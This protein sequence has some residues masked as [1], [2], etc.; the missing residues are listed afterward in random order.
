[1]LAKFIK[2]HLPGFMRWKR[3]GYYKSFSVLQAKVKGDQF[4][5][6]WAREDSLRGQYI[7]RSTQVRLSFVLARLWKRYKFMKGCAL[8]QIAPKIPAREDAKGWARLINAAR[9]IVRT[10]GV[11]EEYRYPD[12]PFK[13]YFY[14]HKVS[15][16]CTFE[17]PKAMRFIDDRQFRERDE[18]LIHGCTLEQKRLL[19]RVQ[20]LYRGYKIRSYYLYVEK[21]ME[22]SEAAER[23]YMT[24]PEK[25]SSLYNYALH[26]HIILHDYD[27]A[28]QL[29]AEA[30]RRME[31]RGPDVG[32]VLYSYA[33]F[34]YFTHDLDY[35]DV[36]VML[37]RARKAE[38]V[39]EQ[40]ARQARGEE[41]SQA[42]DNGTYRHGKI[43]DLANI[44]F[45]RKYASELETEAAWHNYAICRFLIY[46][47]FAT[48]FDAFLE[49]FRYA[50]DDKKLKE[51]FDTMM[52]HFHGQDKRYLESIVRARMTYLAGRDA[53]V[54]NV[55]T[56]HREFARKRNKAAK[57][58]QE[59]VRDLASK[60]NFRKFMEVIKSAKALREQREQLTTAGS[61]L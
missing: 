30:I 12:T 31:W 56:Y 38:E 23:M 45:F 25:D 24:Y 27:R 49:A 6:E 34:A 60:R 58:L 61:Q 16:E 55:K 9:Y 13:I 17:K 44:G 28:R 39:N 50:P 48:S 10:V 41:R 33:I 3:E 35:S 22:I 32:F 20:A 59:W 21:A 15:G 11:F 53:E 19:T 42:I 1:M 8:L 52:R 2:R 47:D 54:Q 26:C 4:R 57:K 29:Y 5:K 43:F 40:Y 37:D 18:K 51:N 46:N 14:R 36:L 7:Q